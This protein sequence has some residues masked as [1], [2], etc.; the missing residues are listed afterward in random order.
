MACLLLNGMPYN[1]DVLDYVLLDGN[2]EVVWE[3][4]RRR[5]TFSQ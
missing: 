3:L 2:S 5:T 1:C 4:L